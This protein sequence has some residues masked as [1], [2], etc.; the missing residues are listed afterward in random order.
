MIPNQ[1][2]AIRFFLIPVMWIL[3]VVGLS[4]Y[5]GIGLIVCFISDAL[6]GYLARR[7]KQTSEFGA[8]FDSLA[9]N[10]L[11]PSALIW[12]GIC[13]P[14]VFQENLVLSILAISTYISSLIVGWIK[15][16]QLGNLH[17]Y[18]SKISG[19]IQYIFIIYTFIASQYSQWLFYFTISLFFLS[20]LETL[21]LQI[22]SIN[23]NQRMGSI[24]FVFHILDQS[25]IFPLEAKPKSRKIELNAGNV[26]PFNQLGNTS[27]SMFRVYL[28]RLF[29]VIYGGDIPKPEIQPFIKKF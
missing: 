9:D 13:K 24:L 1:I 16:K 21:I 5:I 4:N 3:I 11:I 20:S 22:V 29:R 23:V 17:L 10:I 14:S 26:C 2:T 7:L 27:F 18:L 15:F 8:K 28:F 19:L 6:D 25:K 12:L